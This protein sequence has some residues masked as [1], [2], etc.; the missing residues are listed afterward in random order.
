MSGDYGE[1]R[2][3]ELVLERG[4]PGGLHEEHGE[5]DDHEDDVVH[6]ADVAVDLAELFRHL[7]VL[8]LLCVSRTHCRS[9]FGSGC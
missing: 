7:R 2:L 1:R 9:C 6:V 3:L 8:H 4:A 5:R